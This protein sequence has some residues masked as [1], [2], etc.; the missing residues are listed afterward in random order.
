MTTRAPSPKM[1]SALTLAI[2]LAT[3]SVAL[4]EDAPRSPPSAFLD[5]TAPELTRLEIAG[6]ASAL[7]DAGGRDCRVATLPWGVRVECERTERLAVAG[8][9]VRSVSAEVTDGGVRRVVAVTAA[10]VERLEAA[11]AATEPAAG[12]ERAIEA[13]E[14]GASLVRCTAPGT[15][16]DA[17]LGVMAGTL[18]APIEGSLGW[19]VCAVAAT[20]GANR[21]VEVANE[22]GWRIE[23][24]APGAW[25]VR[26]DPIGGSRSACALAAERVV[27]APGAVPVLAMRPFEVRAGSTTQAGELRIAYGTACRL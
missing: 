12:I 13:R 4:A 22:A 6:L 11:L 17:G 7:R 10:R 5:C 14:D 3:P 20:G 1:A 8:I 19:Q 24:L 23:G 18:P 21:C 15:A 2:A 25:R 26:A 27:D 9:P 16:G